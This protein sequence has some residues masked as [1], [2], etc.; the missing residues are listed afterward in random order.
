[1]DLP[2]SVMSLRCQY[3]SSVSSIVLDTEDA[4]QTG[5]DLAQRDRAA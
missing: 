5:Q 3:L 4:G 2:R 1:M